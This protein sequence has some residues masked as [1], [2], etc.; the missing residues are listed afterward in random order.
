MRALMIG[1]VLA[2]AMAGAAM[3]Q[4]YQY[5]P[6]GLEWTGRAPAA[7]G[8]TVRGLL[9]LP[10]GLVGLG[11]VAVDDVY[12]DD[13][14]SYWTG[15]SGGHRY[16]YDRYNGF[17]MPGPI[18]Y[19]HA[20]LNFQGEP[21]EGWVRVFGP[22]VE[23]NHFFGSDG[24]LYKRINIERNRN[25]K[26]NEHRRVIYT[27]FVNMATGERSDSEAMAYRVIGDLGVARE[28]VDRQVQQQE[29][30]LA[31][32]LAENPAFPNWQTEE[33]TTPAEVAAP[34]DD[35]KKTDPT[36]LELVEGQIGP[37]Q[38]GPAAPAGK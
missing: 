13:M 29:A 2:L 34:A 33:F 15:T 11:D 4:G 35:A 21:I 6:S 1:A 14:F 7:V 26:T 27:Y 18:D 28:V 30:A 32:I 19:R 9:R 8:D 16:L 25:R 36:L 5:Q 22:F 31:K 24:V 10:S 17:W 12:A 38:V 23:Y 3:A 20:T 37:L